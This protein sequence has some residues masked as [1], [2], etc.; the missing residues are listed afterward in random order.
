M[1]RAPRKDFLLCPARARRLARCD[2]LHNLLSKRS[3][4]F[5]RRVLDEIPFFVR[6]S[7]AGN[8]VGDING[9][10]ELRE[11]VQPPGEDLSRP[12]EREGVVLAEGYMRD[13]VAKNGLRGK[14]E[15]GKLGR[16]LM[17]AGTE[18]AGGSKSAHTNVI[19][20][21]DDGLRMR[22]SAGRRGDDNRV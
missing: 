17:L 1:V 4:Y 3:K 11:P 22:G 13:L 16:V 2:T 21:S 10:P 7:L 18:A 6:D 19:F 5:L 12:S 9:I 8:D 20:L 15:E 14:R